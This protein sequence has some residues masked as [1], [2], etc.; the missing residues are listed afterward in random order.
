MSGQVCN[1]L[2]ER[3]PLNETFHSNAL[4]GGKYLLGVSKQG[5]AGQ[6]KYVREQYFRIEPRRGGIRRKALCCLL[7][8]LADSHTL[9][10][11]GYACRA[12]AFRLVGQ[13]QGFD[14]VI[15]LTLEDAGHAGQRELDA[16]IGHTV[17]R[18]VIGAYL[19][20]AVTRADL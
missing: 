20:R 17:V 9:Y 8:R 12:Q 4:L 19:L 2:T 15:Y 18:E 14:E 3:S 7:K 16:V 5:G 10:L 13:A 6:A 11:I 1:R